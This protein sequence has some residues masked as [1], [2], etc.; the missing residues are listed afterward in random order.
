MKEE[1]VMQ[2][3]FSVEEKTENGQDRAAEWNGG[4]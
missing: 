4:M 1:N 3:Q 2:G